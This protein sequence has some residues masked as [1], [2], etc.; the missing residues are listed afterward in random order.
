MRNKKQVNNKAT[1]NGASHL[2]FTFWR[3]LS[4]VFLSGRREPKAAW[5]LVVCCGFAIGRGVVAGSKT[6]HNKAFAAEASV[7]RERRMSGGVSR[8]ETCSAL[9]ARN[10]NQYGHS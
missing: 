8:K 9:S 5:K 1:I 10:P 4:P 6:C 3:P 7:P 2:S